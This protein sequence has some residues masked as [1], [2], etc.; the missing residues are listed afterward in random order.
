MLPSD[1]P[2]A[3]LGRL[4]TVAALAA[5]AVVYRRWVGPWQQRWG[6]TDAECIDPLPG[7][8]L[9][10][11]PAAQVTRAVTID[12]PP[13][14]VWPWVVQLG[15]DRGGFYSYDWL[16]NLFGLG[17]HSADRVVGEWQGLGVGD[18]VAA[19]RDRTGGWV[20]AELRPREALC[21][22]VADVGT[23]RAV[24]RDEGA[25]WEFLWT[26][27]LR[28]AP[29]GATRLLV[30]ERTAFGSVLSRVAMAPVGLVSFVMSRRMLLG[31][32]ERAEAAHR[33]PAGEGPRR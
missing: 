12:A 13:E 20:V 21:L 2:A 8:D 23:R 18:I 31:I 10:D 32:K 26:F 19:D 16:E 6:A 3:R 30:R 24:R 29:G 22:L 25:R 1:A 14:E 7:D 27:A 17:I 4:A 28:D 9:V 11:E 33:V 15:A 5:S